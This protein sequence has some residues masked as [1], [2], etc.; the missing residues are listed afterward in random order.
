MQGRE[1]EN[2][3]EDEGVLET[4]LWDS[5]T[6]DSVRAVGGEGSIEGGCVVLSEFISLRIKSGWCKKFT[7]EVRTGHNLMRGSRSRYT[8][9]G[10]KS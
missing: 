4:Q 7:A 5:D 2:S 10:G 6:P 9:E 3:G 8:P 1:G